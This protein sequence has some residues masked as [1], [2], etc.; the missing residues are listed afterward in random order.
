[1]Q[2]MSGY[3]KRTGSHLTGTTYPLGIK[4]QNVLLMTKAMSTLSQKSNLHIYN[5]IFMTL[6]LFASSFILKVKAA[7]ITPSGK[8][9]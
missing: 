1:M 8:Q 4:Q 6:I 3:D 9:P 2:I 5:H 7:E